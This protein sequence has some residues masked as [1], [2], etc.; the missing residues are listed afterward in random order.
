MKI[1]IGELRAVVRR[2]VKESYG[3][4]KFVIK[5]ASSDKIYCGPIAAFDGPS[6]D[7]MFFDSYEEAEQYIEDHWPSDKEDF[8]IEE[9]D[10]G[11]A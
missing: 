1:T 7:A 2:L 6:W 8:L 11:D 4:G 3:D 5:L 10:P 9:M